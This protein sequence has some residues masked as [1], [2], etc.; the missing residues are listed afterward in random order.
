MPTPTI[1]IPVS[2]AKALLIIA[3]S[4]AFVIACAWLWTIADTQTDRPPAVMKAVSVIGIVFFSLGM[5]VGVKKLFDK[6]PG[7]IIDDQGIQDNTGLGKGRFIAWTNIT[8]FKL[9][10]IKRTK[11]IS[12]FVNNADELIAGQSPWKQKMT[13]LTLQNYGTPISIS[14]STLKMDSDELLKL[15]KTRLSIAKE[16]I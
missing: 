2:K 14:S 16:T 9:I 5:V 7:L 12:V 13:R 15:L 1:E 8:G 10:E 3:A 11:L 4:V 6:R